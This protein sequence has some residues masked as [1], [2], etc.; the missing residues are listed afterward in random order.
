MVDAA[1][2]ARRQ[3]THGDDGVD[4]DPHW[5]PDGERLVFR[6][7]RI[8]VPD[9]LSVG[10][11]GIMMVDSDG[12]NE[13]VISGAVGGLFPNWSP[14]GRT[15]VFSTV[16]DGSH[17][18]LAAYDVASGRV[19]DLG[20][21]GEGLDW[22]PDGGA[23]VM[24]REQGTVD[25]AGGRAGG[26]R[27]NWEIWRLAADF[28]QPVRLTNAAGDDTFGGWSPDGSRIAFSTNRHD[29]DDVWLMDADGGG[30]RPLIQ[31]DGGQAAGG[32]LH[33]GRL[34]FADNRTSPRWYLLSLDANT[35]ENVDA[36]DGV[37]GPVA[38]QE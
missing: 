2:G 34:L 3:V 32:F 16:P 35:I 19:H 25:A 31:W 8:H 21:Y 30:Q 18:L 36:L 14:D 22:S 10:L 9:P 15:I 28:T 7:T 29:T 12:L 20:I 13:Q 26:T 24:N 17:E 37:D 33:D 6:S 1:T 5:S 27:Q 4:F 23:L 38:W 11:D